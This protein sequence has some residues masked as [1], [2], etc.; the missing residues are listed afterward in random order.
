MSGSQLLAGITNAKIDGVTYQ[1]EG[2]A[3][4]RVAKVKRDSLM[5]QDGFH[6]FKEM[7]LPGSIK[8][9]LRDS[10]GLSIADFNAMRNSTVVLEL[11]NGKIVTGRNMGTVE[12][13]EVDT[14]E[15]TFE[16]SFEGPEVT[17]QTA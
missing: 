9:S 1:L 10:G 7:P 11:A 12:A 15:A 13:E 16:V 14:E 4:Y 5:G 8:M 6:G 2:K 17:E 3:R